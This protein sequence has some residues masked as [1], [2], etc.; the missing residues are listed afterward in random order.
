M[1]NELTNLLPF[2]RQ[3]ALSRD[4]FLRLGV[5]GAVLLGVLIFASAVLLLPMYV[6]LADAARAKEV[7]LAGIE[8]ALSSADEKALSARLAALTN[9]AAVL[10][11]LAD[12]PSVSNIIRAVIAVSR[13]GIALSSF[14]YTPA[15]NK[16]PGT[17][18]LSGTA[19]TRD[20]LRRYQ[21]ALQGAP[22]ALSATLPVSA[23]AKDIDIAF[24][25]TMTLTP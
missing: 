24:T 10:T 15:A 25:I 6:F 8:S 9:D 12:A 14:A 16:I 1:N 2:R 13:P 21:L 18:A 22:F 3:R 11:A 23:Y 4:Y 20:A 7:R 17:L 5:V 19:A